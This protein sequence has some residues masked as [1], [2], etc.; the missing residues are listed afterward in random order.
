MPRRNNYR[1]YVSV[2]PN[3][4]G[5]YYFRINPCGQYLYS[6]YIDSPYQNYSAVEVQAVINHINENYVP[7]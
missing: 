5:N 7:E 2:P 4:L 1:E 3:T 6:E